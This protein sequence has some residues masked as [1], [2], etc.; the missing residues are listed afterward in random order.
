MPKD[1]EEK[2]EQVSGEKDASYWKQ[3]AEQ[4]KGNA[5]RA[6]ESAESLTA[7]KIVAEDEY[8]TTQTKVTTLEQQISDLQNKVELDSDLVNPAVIK[9]IEALDAQL[10]VTEDKL[11]AQSTQLETYEKTEQTK[12]AEK[13]RETKIVQLCE[14]IE[15]D[16]DLAPKHRTQARQIV[17]KWVK[18]GT[19]KNPED[20]LDAGRLMRKAYKEVSKETKTKTDSPTDK[21]GNSAV[22]TYNPDQQGTLAEVEKDMRKT[23]KINS[24]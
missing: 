17:E 23:F 10:K 6:R 9:R 20:W 18:D 3:Q 1:V 2:K 5:A 8:K 4:E 14:D 7:E 15:S 16:Y 21:G 13:I 22:F 12:Q 24:E 19:E 11:T